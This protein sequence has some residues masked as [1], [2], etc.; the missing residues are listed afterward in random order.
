MATIKQKLALEKI[1]E[2]GGNVTKA[3]RDVGYSEASINNP[4]TLTRSEGFKALLKS[5]GLD[6]DLVVSSLVDDIRNKPQNRA[7]ELK[8]ASEILGLQRRGFIS[9]ESNEASKPIILC[10][11]EVLV[12]K[13]NLVNQYDRT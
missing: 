9:I 8:L 6:D 2:N 1:V 3:M 5:S 7:K 12:Q 13:F 10:M 4:S 11:P